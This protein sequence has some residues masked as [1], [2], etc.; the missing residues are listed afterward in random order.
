MLPPGAMVLSGP[1][2]LLRVMSGSVALEQPESELLSTVSV[3]T[4]GYMEI[5]GLI[6][7]LT[8]FGV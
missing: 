6:S 1:E 4:E 3:T 2:L 8:L 5:W 7:F